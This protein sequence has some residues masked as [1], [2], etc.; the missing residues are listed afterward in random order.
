MLPHK[1]SANLVQK[2]FTKGCLA[3]MTFCKVFITHSFTICN[4]VREMQCSNFLIVLSFFIV[5]NIKC[6]S[7]GKYADTFEGFLRRHKGQEEVEFHVKKVE[8]KYSF[9]SCCKLMH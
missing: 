4:V 5:F 7:P 1:I 9:M 6:F 2:G 8:G 3:H